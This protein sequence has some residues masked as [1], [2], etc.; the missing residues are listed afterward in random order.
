M[1]ILIE[2]SLHFNIK[3]NI[4]YPLQVGYPILIGFP[5]HIGYPIH[6]GYPI[7][8][9]FFNWVLT[10]IQLTVSVCTNQFK[11]QHC[12]EFA[13]RTQV[14]LGT[15]FIVGTQFMLGTNYILGTYFM[16]VWWVNNGYPLAWV[17][18]LIEYSLHFNIRRIGQ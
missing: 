15:Q 4:G 1:V 7:Q 12:K 17:L 14:M 11:G 16:F 18:T 6:F 3:E 8:I 13:S 10:S 2:Y 9:G 5:I